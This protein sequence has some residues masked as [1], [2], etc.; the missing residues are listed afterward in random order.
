MTGNKQ[1]LILKAHKDICDVEIKLITYQAQ[2]LKQEREVLPRQ[3]MS[4]NLST[5]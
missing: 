3:Q 2:F 5:L 1:L 4:I